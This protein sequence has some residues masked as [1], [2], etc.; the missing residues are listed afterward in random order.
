MQKCFFALT[1]L[2]NALLLIVVVEENSAAVLRANVVALAVCC[3]WVVNAVEVLNL[4]ADTVAEVN[5][6]VRRNVSAKDKARQR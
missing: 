1:Y 6:Q 2:S 5:N 4:Q 3:C